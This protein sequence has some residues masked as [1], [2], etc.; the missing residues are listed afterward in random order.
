MPAAIT[1]NTI[2]TRN[3]K[4][5]TSRIGKDMAMMDTDTGNY[6]GLNYVAACI[7][8]MLGSPVKAE[9]IISGL[10]ER[11]DVTPEQCETETM[12]C[13]EEMYNQHLLLIIG[14][15]PDSSGH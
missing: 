12:A 4:Y 13:M 10:L 9:E 6:I 1:K 5:L 2:I 15:G 14:S 3:N 7:W 8:D 11:F